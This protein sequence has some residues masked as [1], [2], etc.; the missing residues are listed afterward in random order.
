MSTSEAAM[1]FALLLPALA[2][3]LAVPADAQN[4]T[5]P[6]GP[7]CAP[8]RDTT[9]FQLDMSQAQGRFPKDAVPDS[10]W[11]RLGGGRRGC[12]ITNHPDTWLVQMFWFRFP[13]VPGV[14]HPSTI[15][16]VSK[17][18]AVPDTAKVDAIPWYFTVHG[19]TKAEAAAQARKLEPRKAPAEL[20]TSK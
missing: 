11:I 7:T 12:R 17:R 2:L 4:I 6:A 20:L 1:R 3:A 5:M 14:H 9:C 8:P 13:G 16:A 10:M 19:R 15:E 18:Y